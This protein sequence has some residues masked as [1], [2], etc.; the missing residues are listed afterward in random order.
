MQNVG[1]LVSQ[2]LQQRGI[3]RRIE[4]VP[5]QIRDVDAEFFERVGG[6]IFPAQ[7]DQR[8]VEAA[9][10]ESRNHPREQTLDAVHARSFPPEVNADVN[11]VQAA[12]N[13]P[14]WRYQS[15]VRLIPSSRSTLGEKPSSVRARMVSKARLFV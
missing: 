14:S 9:V 12:H 5:R 8:H 10:V 2:D 3:G 4:F 13:R 1:L 7:A 15:A 11:D 6:K